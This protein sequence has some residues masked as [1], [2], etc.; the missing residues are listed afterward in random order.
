MTHRQNETVLDEVLR[1][2]EVRKIVLRRQNRVRTFVSQRVSE[3]TGQWEVY[4]EEDLVY[5]RPRVHVDVA[6]LRESIAEN[7][8]YYDE[9]EHILEAGEEPHLRVSYE[10]LVAGGERTRL[11]EFLGLPDAARAAATLRMSSVRQNP[12]P[13]RELVTNFAELEDALAGT[14]LAADLEGT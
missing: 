7:E 6:A 13:I 11:L 4:R 14:A 1:D 8:G 5:E 9:I 10:R 3:E 2:A 12:T